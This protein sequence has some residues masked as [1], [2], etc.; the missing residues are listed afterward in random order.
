MHDVL[1]KVEAGRLAAH[2]AQQV[3]MH[4][5]QRTGPA[6]ISSGNCVQ[7]A[8][9]VRGQDKSIGAVG[10]PAHYSPVGPDHR[11]VCPSGMERTVAGSP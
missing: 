2:A 11:V 9:V 6:K 4:T 1:D 5:Q 7:R 10:R 8:A 3:T